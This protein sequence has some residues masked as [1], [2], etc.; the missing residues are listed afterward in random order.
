MSTIEDASDASAPPRKKP[1]SQDEGSTSNAREEVKV[2]VERNKS[3]KKERKKKQVHMM[4]DAA[5]AAK[6]EARRL[7]AFSNAS[8]YER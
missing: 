4:T 1:S 6:D 2:C 7:F 5:L 3:P 8:A